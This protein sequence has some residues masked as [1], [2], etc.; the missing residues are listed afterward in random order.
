MTSTSTVAKQVRILLVDDAQEI[1]D[2]TRVQLRRRPD[3]QIVAEAA[4]GIEGLAHVEAL[5]PELV[6][7]DIAMP[8]MDGF[9]VLPLMH[10]AAPHTRVLLMSVVGDAETVRRAFEAGADGFL[11]K[12]VTRQVLE[13]TI[14]R[15]IA[16]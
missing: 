4:D 14:D 7:C 11:V 9:E 15:V 5:Q 1:R 3:L 16:R 8:H 2:L 12:G 10:A 6:I 13:D